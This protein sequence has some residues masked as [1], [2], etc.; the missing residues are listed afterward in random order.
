MVSNETDAKRRDWNWEQ[1]GI[2]DGLYVETRLVHIKSGPS[3]GQSKAVLD[4]HVGLEDELVTVWP[5]TVL[6]RMLAEELEARRKGDFERG[7]RIRI[8]PLGKKVGP[9]GEY[10]DFG[11]P[12]FEFAA[13]R[14]SAAQLLGVEPSA[15]NR[16]LGDDEAE[17]QK[18]LELERDE[19]DALASEFD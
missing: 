8:V 17:T 19:R 1:D 16:P 13:P 9:N 15:V 18:A 11:W 10:R 4:F 2:L 12:E 5:T 3:A 14:P 6:K 7:E